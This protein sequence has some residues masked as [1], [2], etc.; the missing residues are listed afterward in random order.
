MMDTR[1][2]WEKC[3]LAVIFT[4]VSILYLIALIDAGIS[5]DF[6]EPI[7]IATLIFLVGLAVYFAMRCFEVEGV[8]WVALGV[9][10]INLVLFVIAFINIADVLSA[11]SFNTLTVTFFVPLA[12]YSLL[13]LLLGVKMI[14]DKDAA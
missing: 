11:L 14:M 4:V 7:A 6:L 9:G 3:A 5:F 10:L 8:Q 13:P 1:K 12:I 2:H